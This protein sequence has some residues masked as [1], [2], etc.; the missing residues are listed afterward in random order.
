[1]YPINS[2]QSQGGEGEFLFLGNHL[3]LDFLNTRPRINGELVEWLPDFSALLRWF[4]AAALLDPRSAADILKKWDRSPDARKALQS[5]IDLREELR[6]SV[7]AWEAGKAVS[8]ELAATLNDLMA[9]H[10][11][12][13]RLKHA[14]TELWFEVH[15]PHDLLAPLAYSAAKL[16]AEEDHPRVRQCGA[17]VLHFLDTSKKGTRRWCSMEICGNRAKVAAHAARQKMR[18]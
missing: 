9:K 6:K 10:P 13:L 16:F 7:A 12:L 18:P 3:A 17:C 1:M 11:M 8:R 15:R 2:S 5:I 14:G 4:Q